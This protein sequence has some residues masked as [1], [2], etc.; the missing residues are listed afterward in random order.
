MQLINNYAQDQEQLSE[1]ERGR[2]I[3]LKEGGWTNRRIA[4]HIGRIDAAIERCWQELMDSGV[5]MT[6]DPHTSVHPDHS[7]TVDRAK[8][9]FVPTATQP[10]T[11][12]CQARLQWCLARS[13]W[14]HAEWGR[15][16]LPPDD[17]RR[18]PGQCAAFTVAHYTG[19]QQVS[20][21]WGAISF[22]SRPPLVVIRGTLTPQRYVEDILRTILQYPFLQDNARPHKVRVAMNY[23]TACQTFPSPTRSPD[24]SPIEP[25]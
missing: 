19:P 22:D 4:R 21:V 17:S 10:A 12:A 14:N 6:W 13:G 2:I 5:M 20:R 11:H 15:I 3:G 1:F 9:T 23:L 18:P 16:P 24:I 7:Q 25:I 8:F